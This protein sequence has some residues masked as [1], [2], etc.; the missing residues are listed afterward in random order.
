MT[1]FAVARVSTLQWLDDQCK[2]TNSST[3]HD[4][5]LSP[6]F[7]LFVLEAALRHF[8][9]TN[10]HK[11]TSDQVLTKPISHLLVDSTENGRFESEAVTIRDILICVDKYGFIV[12]NGERNSRQMVFLPLAQLY[13]DELTRSGL[14]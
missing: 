1:D 9:L 4:P 10:V 14:H 6:F 13:D 12:P 8:A 2:I 3:E 11:C 7:L 5:D